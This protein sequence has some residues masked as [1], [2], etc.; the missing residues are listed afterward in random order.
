LR[1]AG[2]ANINP[3][4]EQPYYE[5]LNANWQSNMFSRQNSFATFQGFWDQ[6]LH[7][8]VFEVPSETLLNSAGMVTSMQQ[9][10]KLLSQMLM[11]L[12]IAF[13]ETVNIGGGQ[14]A[15]NPWLQEMP[16]PVTRC[17][18]GNNLQI[19]IAFDGNRRFDGVG[20]FAGLNNKEVIQRG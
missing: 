1:W 4:A 6:V 5:Y 2:S 10:P 18:W 11:V 15:D 20:P 7:D 8:G 16:D 17:V 9:L 3:G 13:L 12:E 14:Y 19:P